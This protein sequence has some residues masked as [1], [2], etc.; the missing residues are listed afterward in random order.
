VVTELAQSEGVGAVDEW[1]PRLKDAVKK[2]LATE[3]ML[4]RRLQAIAEKTL[5]KD[6]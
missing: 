6:R 1:S 4:P 2:I 3:D 5:S